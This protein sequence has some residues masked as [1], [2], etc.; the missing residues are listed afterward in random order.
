VAERAAVRAEV[1][2]ALEADRK[3]LNKIASRAEKTGAASAQKQ[4]EAAA[5]A[6]QATE[7]RRVRQEAKEQW[8]ARVASRRKAQ[9]A[10]ARK[11]NRAAAKEGQ[12]KVQA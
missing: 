12:D 1:Q 11:A 9:S 4:A 5:A 7:A 3:T 8:Q 6:A 2:R 10:T